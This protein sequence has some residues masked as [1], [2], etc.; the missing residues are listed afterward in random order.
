MGD[1]KWTEEQLL[2]ITESGRNLLVAAAAGAGKTAVLVERIIRK[3]TD[4]KHPVDIDRLLVVTFTNAAAAEMRERIGHAIS[5]ALDKN[6]DSYTLQRQMTLLNKASITT[7]HSFCLDVIRNNFHCIDLDPGFRIADDTECTLMKMELLDELFDGMYEEENR[8]EEFIQLV[9]CYAGSKDDSLLQ[10]MV[11][12]LYEFVQSSPWPDQWLEE[13]S[14]AFNLVE[15]TDFGST[16]WAEVL[17]KSL[18]IELA[19]LC[20]MIRMAFELASSAEG[21]EPYAANLQEDLSG[22]RVLEESCAGGWDE[23]CRAFSAFA[24]G[25]L[26]R[27]GKDADKS[28]QEQVKQIRD[29]VKKRVKKIYEDLFVYDSKQI[30]SDLQTIYPAIKGLAGL[31]KEFGRKYTAKK[32]EKALLDFNDL[33]HL[34]IEILSVRDEEGNILP[35]KVALGL[36]ERFEEIL[37][38]EYQDSN[39]VQEV[40]LKMISRNSSETPNIFMVG[41]VKQSIYRFRQAN[42][43][44]FLEKYKTYPGEGGTSSRKILLFKNFRSRGEVIN[45][46]NFIFKQIMSPNAGELD[47]N[48]MEALNLGASFEKVEDPDAIA[49]GNVELHLLDRTE[50]QDMGEESD[51]TSVQEETDAEEVPEEEEE[52]PDAIR[53][54]A[55]VVVRRIKE[56]MEPDR[57]GR[58]LHV[59]DKSINAYRK[60][61]FRDVV[62][63]LRSTKNW[64]ETFVEELG[65]QGIPA[66]ADSASGY[67]RT[68]EVQVVLSL[69]QI[70]DNPMQDIPLLAVLK[71][72]IGGFSAEE[73][74]DMRMAD[75]EG[76]FFE[77]MKQFAAGEQDEATRRKTRAF[78]DRLQ[79]W[80]EKSLYIPTDELIWYLYED[81]GYYSF[82]G[83]MPGGIQRQA[84]LRILFERARQYEETSYKGLFNFINFIN[85]LKSSSGDMGSAKILGE[86]ENVVRIMSIHKSKGLEF[87]IVFV[88]GC[89]KSFNLQDMNRSILVHQTLG[90]GPDFVD[91]RRRITYPTIPKQALRYKSR[92][93]SLSE[94]MR[95][96]YVALTRAREK[97]I[98][99]GTVKNTE[100]TLSRWARCLE[101]KGNKLP[102]YDMLKARNYL[103]WI[104]PSLIRHKAFDG[105]RRLAGVEE[106]A[107]Q[108]ADNLLEDPSLWEARKWSVTELVSGKAGE[109]AEGQVQQESFRNLDLEKVYSSYGDEIERR[110]SWKYKYPLSS[111]LA[112][113]LTVTELKRLYNER[114]TGESE[115]QSYYLPALVKKPVFLEGAKGLSAVEKGTIMHF[116]MQHLDLHRVNSQQEVEEQIREMIRAELL[117]EQQVQGIATMKIMKFFHS[118]LGQRMLQADRVNREVP[119]NLE[120]SCEEVYGK[121]QVEECEEESVLLQGVIDCFFEEGGEAV[122]VDYKTDYVQ[123]GQT[124]S[125]KDKYKLQIEYYKRALETITGMRVKEKYLYL[126]WNGEVVGI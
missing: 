106:L 118:P 53:A 43:E 24:F 55:R 90:F 107:K 3:I 1:A 94:E 56:L 64:A 36:R 13:K 85:K 97:L 69:L 67:F 66:Y 87:P 83:A 82:A 50:A 79:L 68:I 12:S 62:I 49:G 18:R 58:R 101:S 34:C 8:T 108:K 113:K 38:D 126:F 76:S 120:I 114:G 25:K 88:S 122:L 71:S 30:V 86:N 105:L 102:E 81:S 11:L 15:G 14:E 73:L 117:T 22:L 45:S 5:M 54:E 100:K 60:P 78:L 27:C 84:N 110:L 37:V 109:G 47:Y 10:E 44:L 2:A 33:E 89:G 92:I 61:E 65:N 48:D 103:D 9:E 96:L 17:M 32:R 57:E 80:R 6:P 19:G 124:D 74:I 104:G 125:I 70:I 112:A 121:S 28:K 59:F 16:P 63:L 51:E 111:K 116:V 91:H 41:D 115:S 21:L 40:M 77:A 42:P 23:T 75:R 7:I 35:S 52:L 72:P 4:E 98:L 123:A 31:V 29:E 20:T 46:V 26:G 39:L 93:E 99:T 119:F 95:I